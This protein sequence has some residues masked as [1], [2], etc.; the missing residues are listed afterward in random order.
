MFISKAMRVFI[1][2]YQEKSLKNAA[3]KLYLTVPPVSRM[4]KMTEEWVGESLFIIERNRIV[5]TQAAESIYYQLLPH[6]YA[7]NNV[8]QKPSERSLRLS[9]PQSNTSIL[10]DLLQPMLPLLPTLLSIR[11]AECIHDNDEV[12]I[13][14]QQVTAPAFFD[15]TRIDLMLSLTCPVE[16]AQDWQDKMLLVERAITH[17]SFFQKALAG[18]RSQGF[19]GLLHQVDNMACLKMGFQNGCGLFFQLITTTQDKCH[20]LPFIYHQ[21]LFI[22]VNNLKRNAEHDVFISHIRNVASLSM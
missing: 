4:L 18:L 14:F 6:Y 15:V 20:I 11:N 13:S 2:L 10:A 5:P 9:S 1:T 16:L 21:P 12:F 17:Q 3:D 22:Y 8:F 7:M 19:T